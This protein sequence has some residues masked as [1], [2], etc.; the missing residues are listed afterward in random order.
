MVT[1]SGALVRTKF[2]KPGLDFE[3][4]TT[5]EFY[6]C[7]ICN[8]TKK[9]WDFILINEIKLHI[10]SVGLLYWLCLIIVTKLK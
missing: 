1:E 2:I 8:K 10:S 5:N 9:V 3:T 7:A 4:A 6:H